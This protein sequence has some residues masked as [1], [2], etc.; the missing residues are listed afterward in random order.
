VNKNNLK[1]GI[2]VLLLVG[3]SASSIINEK[4]IS[5]LERL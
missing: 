5:E 4:K 1:F 3:L 2:K